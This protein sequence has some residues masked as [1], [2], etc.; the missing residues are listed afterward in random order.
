MQIK[1][2]DKQTERDIVSCQLFTSYTDIVYFSIYKIISRG[3]DSILIEMEEGSIR[4]RHN[5]GQL[6]RQKDETLSSL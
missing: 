2:L 5:G 1:K 6:F 4:F 3:A